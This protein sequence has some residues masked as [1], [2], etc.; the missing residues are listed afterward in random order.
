[1]QYI[2]LKKCNI[3]ENIFYVVEIEGHI[4]YAKRSLLTSLQIK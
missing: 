1:M 3:F 2:V 4:H